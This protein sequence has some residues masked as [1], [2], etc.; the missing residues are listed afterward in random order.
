M[1][2]TNSASTR[3]VAPSATPRPPE[4]WVTMS[5]DPSAPS[6]SIFEEQERELA[7]EREQE[8]YF[9]KP[10]PYQASTHII[11]PAIKQFIAT[12]KV[13]PGV[14]KGAFQ[15]LGNTTAAKEFLVSDFPLSDLLVSRDFAH[16]IETSRTE[17]DFVSDLYQRHVQWVLTSFDKTN[18][19]Q[20]M[21]VIS[22]YEADALLPEIGK[23][24]C[25]TLHIY[26]P[27]VSIHYPPLDSLNLY[28]VPV[29]HPP[30]T[31]PES[32]L[33]Q[34]NLFSGHLYLATYNECLRVC[35]FL[36]LATEATREG[37]AVAGDGFI[38]QRA[39]GAPATFH[40]SPVKFF[41]LL[42]GQIRR[43]C[44]N[45]DKTHMGQIL[46]GELLRPEDFSD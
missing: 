7:S 21:V 22:P 31:I 9:Q 16:T 29:R 34:L 20:H 46:N 17:L 5:R 18:T 42:M 23:E 38:V 30:P 36:N 35:E 28:T 44:D 41:K 10:K 24:N 8:R 2:H 25:V 19:V 1:N 6:A 11:D 26:T 39:D 27:R 40:T 3:L 14:F 37:W 12:G 13:K 15:T 45:I 32:L 33:V 43:N 4:D